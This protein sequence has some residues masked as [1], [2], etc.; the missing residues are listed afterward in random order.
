MNPTA[1]FPQHARL[2]HPGGAAGFNRENLE[3]LAKE[4]VNPPG[5]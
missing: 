1:R 4:F 5:L 2:I 3:R